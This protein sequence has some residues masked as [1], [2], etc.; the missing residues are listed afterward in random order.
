M[1]R[2][3]TPCASLLPSA[4]VAFRVHVCVCVQT[5]CPRKRP[6]VQGNTLSLI[7]TSDRTLER[8]SH[9]SADGMWLSCA[10]LQSGALAAQSVPG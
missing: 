9:E 7:M 5:C 10:L 4:R 3:C 2:V 1:N 6:S 8:S